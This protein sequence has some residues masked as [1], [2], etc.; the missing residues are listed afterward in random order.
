MYRILGTVDVD[1][2]APEFRARDV[3]GREIVTDAFLGRSSLVLF[4]YRN[5]QCKTCRAELAD[6]ADKYSLV[7]GEDA[8]VIAISTDGIDGVKDLAV[9]L[10]LP[11]PVISDPDAR[12]IRLYD[13]YDDATKTACPTVFIVD[14]QGVV[15]FRKT[16]E[17]LDDLVPAVDIVNRLKSLGIMHGKEPFKSS[18]YR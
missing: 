1:G 6:L 5:G 16:I 11:F 3:Q 2:R 12:I 4:F 13:V 14:M 7:S 15:R 10:R 18:R 9:D 17:G 8:E